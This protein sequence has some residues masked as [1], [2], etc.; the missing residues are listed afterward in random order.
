[1]LDFSTIET[2]FADR[3]GNASLFLITNMIFYNMTTK[4]FIHIVFKVIDYV[5]LFRNN[6]LVFKLFDFTTYSS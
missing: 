5:T 3:D 4:T 1:M 2:A 6:S